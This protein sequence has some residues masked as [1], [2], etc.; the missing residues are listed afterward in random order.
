MAP[1]GA[2]FVFC[3]TR[4][5]QTRKAYLIADRRWAQKEKPRASRGL[6]VCVSVSPR[7]NYQL[8]T[9]GPLP[10]AKR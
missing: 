10:P 7:D 1:R 4:Q 2:I 9:T 6:S 5:S 8:A 3:D